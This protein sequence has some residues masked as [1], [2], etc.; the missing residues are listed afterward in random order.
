MASQAPTNLALLERFRGRV[1]DEVFGDPY[2]PPVSDGSGNDRALLRKAAQLLQEAGCTVKDGKR[3]LPGGKAI[4]IDFLLDEP[5]EPHH[6]ALI[7]NLTTLGTR[8]G[9][10]PGR[11]CSMGRAA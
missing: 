4:V 2:A 10:T 5:F 11:S 8:C 6:M 3:A 9:C 1:P 7:K